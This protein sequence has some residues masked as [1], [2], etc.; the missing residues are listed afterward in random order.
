MAIHQLYDTRS[1][2]HYS[3]TQ[4]YSLRGN[5][6]NDELLL[7]QYRREESIKQRKKDLLSLNFK[8]FLS[9]PCNLLSFLSCVISGSN[10]PEFT[11]RH[12]KDRETQ[13]GRSRFTQAEL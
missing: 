2:P 6:R 7:L 3:S 1:S 9:P 10:E 12:E 8:L 4:L 5:S 11:D 13:N